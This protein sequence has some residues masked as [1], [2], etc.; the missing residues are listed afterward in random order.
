[1]EI[2]ER[3]VGS[4]LILDLR[5]RLALGDG[6]G[7]LKDKVHSVTHEGHRQ[8]LLNLAGVTYVDS[9]GLG[10]IV[11]CYTTVVNQGGQIK[12]VNLTGRVHDLLAITKLLTVFDTFDREADAVQSFTS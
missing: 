7:R 9:S 12:M 8:I 6:T 1:M 10:E 2:Q 4:V 3:T 5:G 11:A